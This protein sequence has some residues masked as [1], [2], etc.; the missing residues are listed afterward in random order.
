MLPLVTME[1]R[2]VTDPE[3]R[4]TASGM[5][6][7]KFRMVCAS[8]KPDPDNDGKWIDDRLL[9]MQ[10]TVFKKQAEN[11][12]ESI[13]KGNQVSVVGRLQTDEWET[14]GGEKRSQVV[15][16]AD[17]VSVP[18]MFRSVA[19]EEG[20]AERTSAPAAEDP[21]ATPGVSASDEPPF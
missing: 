14:E 5:A 17:Q 1:G 21:W 15:C 8:R 9:W 10:V 6:V 4:Y 16:L 13:A 3:L 18:L 2:A 19:P 11:V 12:A 7:A 20:R